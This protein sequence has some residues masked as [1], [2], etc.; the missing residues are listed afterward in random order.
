MPSLTMQMAG[1]GVHAFRLTLSGFP[2]PRCFKDRRRVIERPQQFAGNPWQR[3][4]GYG[5]TR[6]G[7]L[8]LRSSPLR[9]QGQTI[10]GQTGRRLDGGSAGAGGTGP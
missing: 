9:V 4:A 2:G 10:E 8:Y 7:R 1:G 3:A 5:N 6:R